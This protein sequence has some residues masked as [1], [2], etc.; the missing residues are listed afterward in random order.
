MPRLSHALARLLSTV[1]RR[2]YLP[3]LS[4]ACSAQ[5]MILQSP[6]PPHTLVT[7]EI[8][9]PRS[10]ALAQLFA[11]R[12]HSLSARS[13]SVSIPFACTSAQEGEGEYIAAAS[14]FLLV[15]W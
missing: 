3:A 7:L 4:S 12:L 5:D 10:E 2:L 13:S 11:L 14:H 1:S 9:S 8:S 6:S 15:Y